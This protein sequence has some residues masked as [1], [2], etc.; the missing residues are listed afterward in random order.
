[1]GYEGKLTQVAMQADASSTQHQESIQVVGKSTLTSQLEASGPRAYAA[2]GGSLTPPDPFARGVALQKAFY[3]IQAAPNNATV[4]VELG[5]ITLARLFAG[6]PCER[7]LDVLLT[8]FMKVCSGIEGSYEW[9]RTNMGWFGGDVI[10]DGYHAQLWQMGE[11]A[12]NRTSARRS[13]RKSAERAARPYLTKAQA[14]AR[15]DKV[16]LLRNVKAKDIALACDGLEQVG[17]PVQNARGAM[18]L[19]WGLFVEPKASASRDAHDRIDKLER[20]LARARNDG[21]VTE[22]AVETVGRSIDEF[23]RAHPRRTP[24]EIRQAKAKI[25]A[26]EER[27][28]ERGPMDWTSSRNRS[29]AGTGGRLEAVMS[30]SSRISLSTIGGR[31]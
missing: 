30:R 9:F 3:A 17:L 10:T 22:H 7:E 28:V 6:L 15:V 14:V 31:S 16:L 4:V 23:R 18:T 13:E 25:A 27:A 20:A 26:R 24:E 8:N 2:G 5:R 11:R 12:W 21:T 1:M 19:F 29:T